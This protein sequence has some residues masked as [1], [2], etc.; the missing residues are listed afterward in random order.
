[1][2]YS[3]RFIALYLTPDCR[4][5]CVEILKTLAA[6]LELAE[7]LPE[8]GMVGVLTETGDS[9]A[10]T[11]EQLRQKLLETSDV[12]VQLWWAECIDLCCRLRVQSH[13]T[14]LQFSL[15]GNCTSQFNQVHS[16]LDKLFCAQ[17][18]QR[19]AIA[20]IVDQ[21]GEVAE[22]LKIDVP[23]E[24]QGFEH[25]FPDELLVI[26]DSELLKRLD[27]SAVQIQPVNQWVIRVTPLPDE[28]WRRRIL[29]KMPESN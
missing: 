7:H 26:A 3:D 15:D 11:W 9:V 6:S 28:Q 12:T 5:R 10:M 19:L 21:Y 24:Q 14:S 1:M 8:P 25:F 18:E 29:W 4:H 20:L 22:H 17:A 13:A 23:I 2:G 27:P 16:V